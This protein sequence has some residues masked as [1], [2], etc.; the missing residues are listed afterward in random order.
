MCL[1]HRI[2][3][4]LEPQIATGIKQAYGDGEGYPHQN[5]ILEHARFHSGTLWNT[6]KQGTN[7][8]ALLLMNDMGQ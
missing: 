3:S 5:K 7:V 1:Q 8:L 6:K 2:G 4:R